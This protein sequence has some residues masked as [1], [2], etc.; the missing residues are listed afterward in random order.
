MSRKQT[1]LGKF[2]V[3]Q[4]IITEAQLQQALQYQQENGI[5]IGRALIDLGLLTEREL[6]RALG[7]Q[8]GVQYVNLRSYRI[9]EKVLSL[10]PAELAR[11][12]HVIPL[13]RIRD[14]LTVA[15]ENPLDLFCIDAL[16]RATKM[17]IEPVV[18]SE[19]DIREVLDRFYPRTE[20]A[21]S[22]AAP[23]EQAGEAS[24]N[25]HVVETGAEAH[26]LLR[27][28]EKLIDRL[29]REKAYRAFLNGQALRVHTAN[30]YQDWPLPVQLDTKAFVRVMCNLAESQASWDRQPVQYCLQKQ[31][32]GQP[33]YIHMLSDTTG[34]TP[35]LT[36]F[37]Q[38]PRKQAEKLD[39][40]EEVWQWI[41][42]RQGIHLVSANSDERLHAMYYTLLK[43]A[44]E[45]AHYT[46]SL[47]VQATDLVTSANQIVA[48]NIPAQLATIRFALNS[49]VDFL[50]IKDIVQREVMQE[51][52]AL[53]AHGC[54]VVIG[55]IASNPWDVVQQVCADTSIAATTHL[56]SVLTSCRIDTLRSIADEAVGTFVLPGERGISRRAAGEFEFVNYHWRRPALRP[57]KNND[58]WLEA[59]AGRLL[60]GLLQH[61]AACQS[62]LP[63]EK[64][65]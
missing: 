44:S 23:I 61:M 31:L 5:R 54:T 33:A 14:R 35:T 16:T 2:L 55:N 3:E 45:V 19:R 17:K 38:M 18:S 11:K 26:N 42:S 32:G 27:E 63:L 51:C 7:E 39:F 57:E 24:P 49:G 43:R 6:I 48:F 8:L 30:G 25:V 34:V 62:E 22:E 64:K 1:L 37:V 50:F 52:M 12:F 46:L 40:L 41:Q 28:I 47:E 15:M 20:V 60:E 29:L 65:N 21:G 59:L 13:F 56:Q 10:I 9:D 36:L 4:D 53:A 58:R